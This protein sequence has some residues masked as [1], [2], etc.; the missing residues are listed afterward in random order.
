[1]GV[2]NKEIIFLGNSLKV[3]RGFPE[4]VKREIGFVLRCAQQNVKHERS[5]PLKGFR[6]VFE[7]FSDYDKSTYRAIYT[8]KIKNII[9]VLH[10]FQKKSKKGI[11]TPK[12]EI[13]L[14]RQRYNKLLRSDLG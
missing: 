12:E 1:V 4:D 9:Y 11:Q 8:V 5:K 6:G 13:E 14:I 10:V 7:I 2:E 3:L